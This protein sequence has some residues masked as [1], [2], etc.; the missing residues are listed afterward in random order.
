MAGGRASGLSMVANSVS[1]MLG[2]GATMAL[3]FVFW[4]LAARQFEPAEVGIAAGVVAA[5]MLCTQLAVL[6]F[7]AAVISHLPRHRAQ[8]A[9]L[10]DTTFGL[11]TAVAVACA[12]I[13]LLVASTFLDELGTVSAD[14]GY[15]SLFVAMTVFGT[16]GIVLDQVSISLA[17]GDQILVRGLVFGGVT[18]ALVALAPV[19]TSARTSEVIFLP[20]VAAGLCAC[21]VGGLQLSRPP[22]S[23]RPGR[24]A[25]LRTGRELMRVGV[26]NYALTLTER[27]PGLIIPI[28]VTELLSPAANAT[29]Y[30]VWMLAWV[31]YFVPISV[32]LALFAEGSNRPREL[33]AAGRRALRSSLAIGGAAAL[34][35]T[36]AA[37][38]VLSLLGP[39]YGEAGT[40]PL[41][42]LVLAFLPLCFVQ[43]Y[44]ATCR[45]ARSLREALATGA[46]AAIASVVAAA[47]AGSA[48][49]LEG[50][51]V[52]W[53]LVQ[54]AAGV[55]S[56]WRLRALGGDAGARPAA[57]ARAARVLE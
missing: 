29:W 13:F 36:F 27:A 22:L 38:F 53:V 43:A 24:R 23:Y 35:L 19:L 8:P 15:A 2:K 52:A 26:P 56:L 7:G 41:R 17:R 39:G 51:A 14:P 44:F 47:L 20:W 1:V 28:V 31:V 11:T 42:I 25:D 4:V 45:A 33:H 55:W 40:S 21:A 50:I 57:V 46:A 12:G 18:V 5:M 48:Y 49:G 6:G 9:R 54:A 3:G 10:L 37:P 16:L 30:A 34:C 32:G